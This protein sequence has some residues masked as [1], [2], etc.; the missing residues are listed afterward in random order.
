MISGERSKC[1][2]NP[3]SRGGATKRSQTRTDCFA[4]ARN[5]AESSGWA[6]SKPAPGKANPAA[7]KKDV[8]L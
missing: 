5:D 7:D 1:R 2:S 3:S 8:R 6:K 4:I